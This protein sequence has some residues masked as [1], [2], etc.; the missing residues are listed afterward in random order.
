MHFLQNAEP[1]DI[2]VYVEVGENLVKYA[3]NVIDTS[4]DLA[5]YMDEM[6][7]MFGATGRAGIGGGVSSSAIFESTE[8]LVSHFEKHGSEFK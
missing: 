2:I 3:D 5:K 8:K 7:W 1:R 6:E 4:E